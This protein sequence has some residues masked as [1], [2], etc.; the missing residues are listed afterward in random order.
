MKWMTIC[1]AA[2]VAA[3]LTPTATASE[4]A[5][6]FDTPAGVFY[7]YTHGGAFPDGH[8]ASVWQESNGVVGCGPEAAIPV[9]HNTVP[10]GEKG[11]QTAA[12][13]CGAAAAD[14]S[15]LA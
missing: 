13:Q 7:L 15:L 8:G 14:T 12:G 2:L 4:Y 1:L 11:L 5:A 3:A 9:W 10:M 6:A